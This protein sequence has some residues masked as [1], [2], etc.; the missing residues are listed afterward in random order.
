MRHAD[1]FRRC[2]REMDVAGILR[3]WAHTNPSLRQPTPSEA[4]IQL[5]IARVEAR[6]MSAKAKAYSTA[7]LDELG[8]RKVKG[9]W[10]HGDPKPVEALSV[11]IASKSNYPE[12]KALI[13][14]VMKDALLN[15]LAKGTTE[16][17]IQREKMLQARAKRRFKM[18]MA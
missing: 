10:V 15:E 18:R 4:L 16:P 3:V 12:V 5:H 13:E 1:E 6:S 8:Y 9:E 2:L 14:R 7:L 17:E 11:G